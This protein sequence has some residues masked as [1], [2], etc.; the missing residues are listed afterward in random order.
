[1]NKDDFGIGVPSTLDFVMI[2]YG[3]GRNQEG[4]IGL[5]M[6][7]AKGLSLCGLYYSCQKKI[8]F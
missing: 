4:E 3:R 5:R 2:D 8:M 1:M 6:P 7:E